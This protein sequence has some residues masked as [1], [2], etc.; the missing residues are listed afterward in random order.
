[1]GMRFSKVLWEAVE[2]DGFVL[3]I[4]ATSDENRFEVSI[5]S[6][7]GLITNQ[8]IGPVCC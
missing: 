3:T 8:L 4:S 1:M 2:S 6:F 5:L 7:F